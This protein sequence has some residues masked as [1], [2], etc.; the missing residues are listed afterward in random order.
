M[1]LPQRARRIIIT[2]AVVVVTISGTLYGAGLKMNTEVKQEVEKYQSATNQERIQ[3][4]EAARE[5]LVAKRQGLEKQM[6][7][8]EARQQARQQEATRNAGQR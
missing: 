8:I 6:Q 1:P 7:H 5:I 3:A 2:G 4:L